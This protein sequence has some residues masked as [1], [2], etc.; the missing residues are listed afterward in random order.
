MTPRAIR[1][2]GA[3]TVVSWPQRQCVLRL[4]LL[5]TLAAT[6][7]WAMGDTQV[8]TLTSGLTITIHYDAKDDFLV[9]WYV[10]WSG[11][12]G[13]MPLHAAPTVPLAL[14]H[15]PFP[16]A[17]PPQARPGASCTNGGLV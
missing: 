15:T 16:L 11:S 7:P 10:A 1:A 6:A 5:L 14:V 17:L 4:L 12:P 8:A 9:W 3:G 13:C 2:A